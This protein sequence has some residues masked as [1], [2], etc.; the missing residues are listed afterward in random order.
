MNCSGPTREHWHNRL[1]VSWT[2]L[3][4]EG[5]P[6]YGLG[7]WRDTAQRP[8]GTLA[9]GVTDGA[10]EPEQWISANV[11]PLVSR[12]LGGEPNRG[13]HLLASTRPSLWPVMFY[14]RADA[15]PANTPELLL[16]TSTG[17]YSLRA[18]ANANWSNSSYRAGG[19]AAQWQLSAGG[20]VAVLRFDLASVSGSFKSATLRLKV[21]AFPN[22]GGRGQVVQVFEADP[23]PLIS[24]D[25]VRQPALGLAAEFQSFA[26]LKSSAHPDLIF[27]D[28]FESPG[29]FDRGFTPAA[30]R[31]LNPATGTIYA[32]GTISKGSFLSADL[33]RE[34]SSGAGNRGTPNV[35][36]PEL[37]G[38]YW[39]YLEEDFGTAIE[40]AVKIPAMG[41]QFGYW[42]PVGYWQQ[43][44]GNG[45]S[46][47][48]GLKVDNG[49]NKNFEYQGHSVRFLTGIAPQAGDG[50]PYEG[51]FGIGIYP[52]NL[53]QVGPFPKG[54][55]FPNIMIRK[56][57]WYCVDMRVKQNSMSGVQDALGNY[58]T[59]NPDGA[60]EVWLNGLKAYSSTDYRWRRHAEFGVQGIWL[61]VYHGGTNAAPSTMHYRLDRV[62]LARRYIGPPRS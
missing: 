58:S 26:A 47:G 30:T 59:A 60:Y 49:P 7:N 45:G 37:F 6:L 40:D 38:Q 1:S 20:L 11:G 3:Y 51:W 2:R 57:Q 16:L 33:R 32:R 23:P 31:Q 18:L 17:S 27:A 34:V 36:V 15:N 5:H 55:V 48:S 29:P 21:K 4:P 39:L 14:G 22:G 12:W 35:V 9:Y 50:D 61:D 56:G 24:P 62:A 43:T 19:S 46:P 52:Y 25:T 42:N 28:D 41:L 10:S 44:T 54:A 53:D 8:E 13:F